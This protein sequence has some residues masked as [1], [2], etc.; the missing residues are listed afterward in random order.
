MEKLILLFAITLTL[1]NKTKQTS[2][3]KKDRE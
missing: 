1:K 2:K 3:I